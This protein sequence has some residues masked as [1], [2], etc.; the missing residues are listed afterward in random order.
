MDEKTI[1]III[2]VAV[3]IIISVIIEFKNKNYIS[4]KY[5]YILIIAMYFIFFAVVLFG[6]ELIDEIDNP[7]VLFL[8]PAAI[9]GTY[10][11]FKKNK[12]YCFKGINKNF[13]KEN[14]NEISRIIKEYKN[15]NLDD[16]SE[17]FLENNNIT[18]NNVN[19]SQIEEC[20]LL[21]GNYLDENRKKNTIN[22]YLIYYTKTIIVPVVIAAAVVLILNKINNH[23]S[24]IVVVEQI[25]IK[26]EFAVGNTEGNINNYGLVAETDESIYYTNDIKL[27]KSD[28]DLKNETVLADQPESQGKNTLNI[29][30]DWIFYR[31]GKEIRRA[32]TDGTNT[33]T[34]FKG[35]SLHMQVVGNWIYFIS[36][37]DDKKICRIDVNGQNKQFLR[38]ESVDDMAIYDG[39]IYY[40]YEDQDDIY[41]EVINT[42]RTGLQRLANIKTRNMIVVKEYIYYLDDVEEILYRMSLKDKSIEK[43]SNEQILKFIKDDNWI[44]YTLKDP[45]N[46]DWRYKGLFRMNVDGSNVLALDSENY[47]DESG[48]GVTEDFVFYVYTNGKDLPSLK[49]INKDGTSVK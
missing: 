17:I 23:D 44:F 40:S 4:E 46:S 30:E 18:F 12:T 9:I 43:L 21:I 33:E 24:T 3:Y 5:N 42:D 28:K 35:Y 7:Y 11:V 14:K 31:Q 47:L 49:I 39:K 45:N 36:L 16:N 48:F 38:S 27:Y 22:D 10:I 37:G 41:L 1:K 8:I 20:L 34:I 15:N 25:N 32:R 6:N 13:I 19:K 2:I 29:V 26:N